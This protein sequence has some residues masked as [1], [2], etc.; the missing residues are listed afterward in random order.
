MLLQ[1]IVFTGGGTGGHVYPGIAVLQT[2]RQAQED[3]SFRFVWIGSKTGIEKSIVEGLGL[4]YRAIATGK[5]RRY[6]DW[7]NVTDLIRI[8]EGYFQAK[9]HLKELNPVFVFSKGGFVSVPPVRAAK[10]L[11]IPVYSHESDLDPGLAT[12]LNLAASR[13]IFC[14]YAESVKYFPPAA[15]ARVRVTGNPVRRELAAGD[16]SWIRKTWNI[17]DG[18][19]ILLVLGGSLGARQL[20]ELVADSL[21]SLAG[22][23]FVIHQT[24]HSWVPLSDSPWYVSRPFFPTEMPDLYAGADIIFGRAGAGTLWEAA[25]TGVPLILL[26]LGAGSRGDQVRNADLFA[27]RGAAKVLGPEDGTETLVAAIDGFLSDTGA[28]M[29][30]RK[31]L[32]D[33]RRQRSR[34]TDRVRIAGEPSRSRRCLTTSYSRR[35]WSSS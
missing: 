5:L 4:E 29:T 16:P 32:Q 20:N 33:P 10:A 17:P 6:F 30:A 19:G 2:L 12:R 34:P 35:G 28:R 25:A 11:K 14:A 3:R 18:A 21:P 23:V 1:V 26:P 15:R 13:L 27:S 24:G 9:R 8:I 7:R 31:A 22:R